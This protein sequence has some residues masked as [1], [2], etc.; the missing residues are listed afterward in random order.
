MTQN[1]RTVLRKLF[2]VKKTVI[3]ETPSLVTLLH[4][5][6]AR[7]H[8]IMGSTVPRMELWYMAEGTPHELV[9]HLRPS[10]YGLELTIVKVGEVFQG[11][12]RHEP[13]YFTSVQ[14]G[15]EMYH[16]FERKVII[17]S[18]EKEEEK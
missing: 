8:V 5:S 17:N 15:R 7:E 2:T 6:M 10:E 14:N 11:D 9:K 16:I 4:I 13:Q 12:H 1:D 3:V 18:P